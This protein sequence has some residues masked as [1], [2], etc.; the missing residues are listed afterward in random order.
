MVE[1]TYQAAINPW[2]TMQPFLQIIANP[3]GSAPMPN[4]PSQAIPNATIVGLRANV[5]F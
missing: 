2:L 4:N 3:G 1:L 5:A